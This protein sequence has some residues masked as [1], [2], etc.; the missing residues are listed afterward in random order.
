MKPEEAKEV[1][2]LRQDPV[3]QDWIIISTARS[4]K[5]GAFNLNNSPAEPTP[6]E[7]CPFEDPQ[8]SG[9]GEPLLIYYKPGAKNWSLQVI[10]NRFPIIAGDVCGLEKREGPYLIQ[11]QAGG[12][13]EVVITK[14]HARSIGQMETS[15]VIEIIQAYKERYESLKASVCANYILIMHNHG[16]GAGASV[17]HPHSQILAV[18]FLP[19]DIRRSLVGSFNYFNER[20]R[21]VHCDVLEWELKEKNRIV[22]ENNSMVALVP[23]APRFSFEVR[24]FPKQHR[25]YFEE[26]TENETADLAEALRISLGKFY[27]GLN[28]VSYNFFIHTPPASRE[29]DYSHYHWHLEINPRVSV[30][31]GFEL[32][33]GGEV[34]EVD[35]DEAAKHL[36]SIKV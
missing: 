26:I 8:K 12:Y 11:Q 10:K 29:I 17:S 18:S 25:S 33:T 35:P 31:G 36:R 15:E 6:I 30:W 16:R 3:S 1:S 34:I 13:H 19:A 14:D 24:I 22:F 5:P 20:H 32:G 2:Q 21:C 27:H 28:N 9:N 23:F 7:L 4:K